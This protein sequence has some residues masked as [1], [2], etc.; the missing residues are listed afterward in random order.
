MCCQGRTLDL[1]K[2]SFSDT[3]VHISV[4]YTMCTLYCLQW[5]HQRYFISDTCIGVGPL[6]T[7][8]TLLE[9]GITGRGFCLPPTGIRSSRIQDEMR[10]QDTRARGATDTLL[11]CQSTNQ[12]RGLRI[13]R[14]IRY[15]QVG[16]SFEEEP[17]SPD[18]SNINGKSK[19][20]MVVPDIE[21]THNPTSQ[22][23]GKQSISDQ[24]EMFNGNGRIYLPKFWM[25]FLQHQLTALF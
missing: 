24:Q 1:Q 17:P 6:Y 21:A 22:I 16:D 25:S 5:V 10:T 9:I 13:N 20:K 14:P 23:D 7:R 8:Y 19:L 11:C 15:E 12:R 18:K 3:S 4:R 2:S